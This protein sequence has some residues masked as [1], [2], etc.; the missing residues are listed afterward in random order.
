M[1]GG[2]RAQAR[3]GTLLPLHTTLQGQLE[4]I[5]REYNFP[6]IAGLVV[7]LLETKDDGTVE[8]PMGPRISDEAWKLLWSRVM[9]M[10]REESQRRFVSLE[11]TVSSPPS[12]MEL[13]DGTSESD[14]HS[15]GAH[16]AE[17]SNH[18]PNRRLIPLRIGESKNIIS[19]SPS[20]TTLS[21]TYSFAS[22]ESSPSLRRRLNNSPH[23]RS[24]SLASGDAGSIASSRQLPSMPVVGKIEFDIDLEKGRWFEQW[25]RRK[26]GFTISSNRRTSGPSPVPAHH[27]LLI[28]TE[29][30]A[31]QNTDRLHLPNP[32]STS[33]SSRRTPNDSD[34]D[35][36]AE[37]TA[38]HDEDDR[39]D[40]TAEGNEDGSKGIGLGLGLVVNDEADWRDLRS[41][42]GPDVTLRPHAASR[43]ALNAF[44]DGQIE[45]ADPIG[46]T[47]ATKDLE[48]VVAMWNDHS[49][50]HPDSIS[51]PVTLN[52]EPEKLT[53]GGDLV[54]QSMLV[55]RLTRQRTIPP[56]LHLHGVDAG[57]PSVQISRASPTSIQSGASLGYLN[58]DISTEYLSPADRS[59][60]LSDVSSGGDD[61]DESDHSRNSQ[62]ALRKKLDNLERVG[63]MRPTRV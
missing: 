58:G 15:H 52:G 62:I 37:Y 1:L 33:Q 13:E 26:L 43:V 32:I 63:S 22:V 42:R 10:E 8:E 30:L 28:S 35:P 55:R 14:S 61:A 59:S 38:L 16:A 24:A 46:V 21:S 56:P 12:P 34:N 57:E 49:V 3:R 27:R 11:K 47:S 7:Y 54:A 44:L 6:S 9:L 50:D 48:E 23:P 18:P 39:Y 51:T 60:I 45:E 29:R 2:P 5:K 41:S 53:P 31:Q 25:S 36:P 4:A 17:V 40:A 20:T 19:S